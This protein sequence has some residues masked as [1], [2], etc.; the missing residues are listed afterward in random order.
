MHRADSRAQSSRLPLRERPGAAF[1]FPFVR[2]SACASRF[3]RISPRAPRASSVPMSV[4]EIVRRGRVSRHD[5]PPSAAPARP[6]PCI[7]IAT[8]TAIETLKRGGS[9]VDAAIAANACLGFL[10]PTSCGIG[11]DCFAM[12]WDPAAAKVVG[13]AGSGRSPKSL[14]LET[15]RARSKE[16]VIPP[17]GAISVSTPGAVDAW[18]ALH[19]RYGRLNWAELFQSRDP[20]V[21]ERRPAASNDRLQF[22]AQPRA[23]SSA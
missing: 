1:H 6:P 18:W 2:R 3:R 11:G 14:G 12:L 22:Q 9:A 10:E 5:P 23:L 4:P 20:S 16:G 21:R 7:R 15:V 17:Y 19:Q 13:L 8:L